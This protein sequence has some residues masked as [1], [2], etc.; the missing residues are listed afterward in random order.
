MR[1]LRGSPS[2]RPPSAVR[3]NRERVTDMVVIGGGQAGFAA[4]H[5]LRRRKVDFVILHAQP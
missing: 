3:V 1:G 4:G 5:H 2:T